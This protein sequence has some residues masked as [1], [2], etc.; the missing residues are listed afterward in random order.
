[1]LFPYPGAVSKK[2]ARR[3][4]IFSSEEIQLLRRGGRILHDCLAHVAAMVQSGVTTRKLDQAAEEFLR[5]AGGVPAFKGYR[6]FPASLCTSVNDE[7]VHG[8]PGRRIL[9]EG[10]IVAL[11][12]GV[13]YGGLCTDACV[14]VGV[15]RISDR[16]QALLTATQAA[17]QSGLSAIHAG[18]HTGDIGAAVHA[19]LRGRGFDVVRCLTGHGLGRT[20]HQFPDI[21][22]FGEPGTGPVLPLHTIVAIEPISTAG[23]TDVVQDK[24][25]WT[26]RITD[27]AISAHFEHTVLVTENGN[28]ILT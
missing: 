15:G 2:K 6:G 3:C 21:P 12:C 25:G 23:S 26:L 24:D 8:I 5:D 9:E 22:N 19:T 10:D 28:E 13:T 27:G 1:M 7:S 17:L 14:T 16:A 20:L 18:V 4:Q 11:D